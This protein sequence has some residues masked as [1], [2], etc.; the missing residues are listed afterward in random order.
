MRPALHIVVSVSLVIGLTGCLSPKKRVAQRLP[1]LRLQWTTNLLNQAAIPVQRVDWP[2][3]VALLRAHN[4]K[5]LRARQD[6]T[7]N[8]ESV[9]QVFKDL[10][11]TI[12][13]RANVT[14]SLKSIPTTSLDDVTFS[15]D[16]FFNVPG[17]VNM[18]AR[19][20]SARL[21]LLR[22]QLVYE[23]TERE[24]IIELYKLFWGFEEEH[25]IAEQLKTE[26][27][28]A[29]AI[30]KVDRMAG[31]VLQEEM[32][33][34]RLVF[35]KQAD[36][37]Q[38]SA[39]DLLGD[40][41]KRWEFQ[42]NGWPVLP[43]TEAALPLEDSNRVA[44]LQMKLVAVELVAAWAQVKGIKLQYWP[45][46]TIFV[47]GPPIYQ[48]TAGMDQVWN[49]GE[50][51]ASADLFWRLDTRGNV[52]RQLRQA[53]RDQDL[54]WARLRQESLALMDKLLVAQKLTVTVHDE[55]QQLHQLLPIVEQ[56]VPPQD[57]TGILKAVETNRALRDQER[58]LR[59]DLAELN[60]LFWFVDENQWKGSL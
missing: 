40:R 26:A 28:L 45:E 25:E 57:Y 27:A 31:Q 59:R 10:I 42:T 29:E 32:R 33:S 60:L 2:G 8:Q 4:L 18:N 14:R 3:A 17:V 6:I 34:R 35:D 9:R 55:L 16:G 12:N 24:Q 30:E 46:L 54:Q 41:S 5:L 37:L 15:A 36:A 22:S 13:L 23:L 7:N 49:F 44:Q 56:T 47:T 38:V 20:F 1:E 39:G 19:L 52:S 11:P 51:R 43:Y 48:H 58:R 21:T 50:L 53:R